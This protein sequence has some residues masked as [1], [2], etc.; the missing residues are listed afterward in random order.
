MTVARL[1]P[2]AVL[3]DR[4]DTLVVNVPYNGD[5]DKV[6]A[7]PG[8]R[9]ALDRLRAAGIAL[10]VV[11]NQSGVQRGLLTLEQVECVNRRV[12]DLVGSIGVWAICPHG[13]QDDCD[14]R[15]PRPGLILA[16]AQKLGVAAERCA[17]IGDI[18]AD[19]EA[20]NAAGARG[21]L[22]PSAATRPEEVANAAETAPDLQS[23]VDMLLGERT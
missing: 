2:Q 21:V 17:V 11:S 3:F 16:A 5:P 18:G 13:P 12:E 8:A 20:A 7:Q 23:A 22:V 4:D 10:G 15:K 9:E 19:M 6:Q 14:C 1:R